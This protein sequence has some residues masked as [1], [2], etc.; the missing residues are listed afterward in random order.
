M[1]AATTEQLYPGSA[2]L[3]RLPGAEVG[4]RFVVAQASAI[5]ALDPVLPQIERAA[6]L[7]AGSLAAGGRTGYA[8]AGSS[9]LM[10]LAD[11]LELA[12]TFGIPPDRTP[13]LFAGGAAALLHMK[14]AVE[15]DREAA[16]ADFTASGLTAGDTVIAVSA[17]GRTPY[18]LVIAQAAR[19]AGVRVIGIAN[20]AGSA[21]LE[22][23]DVAILLD[24]GAELVAGSTR[25]G[26]ATAQKAALNLISVLCGLRLGHVHDGYMVNVVA[27]NEKLLDR[28]ERIVASLSATDTQTARQALRATQGAVKP[29]I[30]VAQ[31]HSPESAAAALADS[32]GHLE[33]HLNT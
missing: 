14:G 5:A 9:G 12:G 6:E 33:P 24:T 8:G 29:A 21:L 1:S 4:R 18:A 2:G 16:L 22:L 27:D 11:A 3:H 31:G 30:L 32:A 7:M 25:L 23:S 26:A 20:V 10:A 28:A 13:V 17:S 15:D 19:A